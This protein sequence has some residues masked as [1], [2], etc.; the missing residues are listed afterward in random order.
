VPK[1]PAQITDYK[2]TSICPGIISLE[3]AAVLFKFMRAVIHDMRE[4]EFGRE[5]RTA[6]ETIIAQSGFDPKARGIVWNTRQKWFDEDSIPEG[7]FR[8]EDFVTP[9]ECKLNTE[10][11]F[12]E[13]GE[14]DPDQEM[15]HCLI[16]GFSLM[17]TDVNMCIV[18]CPHLM[19][20][21]IGFD[22]ADKEMVRR[23]DSELRYLESVCS[24]NAHKIDI[25][26][27]T[28]LAAFGVIPFRAHPQGT[29]PR[30]YDTRRRIIGDLGGNR[31]V[32]FDSSG[33][34]VGILNDLIRTAGFPREGKVALY[35]AMHANSILQHAARIWGE[36][37]LCFTDDFKDF[38]NQLMWARSEVWLMTVLWLMTEAH[39]AGDLKEHQADFVHILELCMC[40]GVACTSNW[41]QRFADGLLRI[42]RRH[43]LR[44]ER[45]LLQLE[46]KPER[47][48]YIAKRAVLSA[49]T[50]IEQMMLWWVG[51]YTDDTFGQVVGHARYL[52]ILK[53]W[54]WL[55]TTSNLAM[56]D[57]IKRQAGTAALW[58]GLHFNAGIGN[59]DIP[60]DK[61]MRATMALRAIADGKRVAASEPP[62]IAGL[63]GHLGPFTSTRKFRDLMQ[64]FYAWMARTK[65][66]GP[67]VLVTANDATRA[68][69]REW[70]NVLHTRRGVSC[71]AAVDDEPHAPVAGA[72]GVVCVITGDAA[73]DGAPRPGLAG[74][75]HGLFWV[76]R[77]FEEDYTGPTQIPITALELVTVIISI[78]IFGPL[79]PQ[80]ASV[81]PVFL[82]D[83]NTSVG[84]LSMDSAKAALQRML[85]AWLCGRPEYDAIKLR[86]LIGQCFG[87]ANIMSDGLS[88]GHDTLVSDLAKQMG[89]RLARLDLPPAAYEVLNVLRF[90]NLERVYNRT[91]TEEERRHGRRYS[92]DE[93]GN[94]VAAAF[95]NR[96]WSAAER[97]HGRPF[98]SNEEGDAVPPDNALPVFWP[99]LQP[100]VRT[101]TPHGVPLVP[102]PTPPS[103]TAQV[104][105]QHFS[106]LP[107]P[108]LALQRQPGGGWAPQAGSATALFSTVAPIA[109]VPV[110]D[111]CKPRALTSSAL[112]RQRSPSSFTTGNGSFGARREFGTHQASSASAD[113]IL[114]FK[115]TLARDSGRLAL[116]PQDSDYFNGLLT[117]T[118]GVIEAG[119]PSATIGKETAHMLV[120]SR[121]CDRLGTASLRDDHKANSGE[122]A[123]GHAREVLL[124][125][126]FLVMAHYTMT[127]RSKS[128]P[129]AKPASAL[130]MVA[131]VRRHHARLGITLAATP[132]LAHVLKGLLRLYVLAHGPESLQPRRKE[133]LTNEHTLAI[134]SVATGTVISGVTVDWTSPVF[135]T[136]AALLTTLR[137]AGAR[138]ADLIPPRPDTFRAPLPE[139]LQ[140]VAQLPGRYV[141][142]LDPDIARIS[143]GGGFPTRDNLRWLFGNV[144]VK[145]PTARQL[146][147]IRIGDCA[148]WIPGGSKSD[149]AA[150]EFGTK[151]VYLP[152][153]NNPVNAA[154]RLAE[155]ELA[156]PVLD[157]AKEPMFP[158]NGSG[159]S[160]CHQLA[161]RLFASLA[162]HAL[163][164]VKA[165]T[166]S[167]H[168]GRIWLASALLS[169]QIDDATI[170]SFCRWKCAASVKIYARMNARDYAKTLASVFDAD[171]SALTPQNMRDLPQI[172]N[173]DAFAELGRD[174]GIE[175]VRAVARASSPTAD[176]AAAADFESAP[177]PAAKSKKRLREARSGPAAVTSPAS[178]TPAELSAAAPKECFR[179]PFGT[180]RMHPC[181]LHELSSAPIEESVK[182]PGLLVATELFT[183]ASEDVCWFRAVLTKANKLWPTIRFESGK[184]TSVRW[185]RLRLLRL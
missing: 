46:T 121:H 102:L 24:N 111:D 59:V 112:A 107:T 126:T 157:R 81:T 63:L 86:A 165:K 142:Q 152:Y 124:I 137:H 20:L 16:D 1:S 50:G 182:R 183:N 42:L 5:S 67:G 85:V 44:E 39:R 105:S 181:A 173:D 115:Q 66:Q 125:T 177:E 72:D 101:A 136:F 77:L 143:A 43:I 170:Q 65:S 149:Q 133:P 9:P 144:I 160:L 52:R 97:Q 60:S 108:P 156:M 82:S 70:I 90:A 169:R 93:D 40:F 17:L 37:V 10:F 154:K 132:S 98:S 122:D 135:I 134:L 145:V 19:S 68:A 22:K 83:S 114:R 171:T 56:A 55:T 155:L 113:Q 64:P 34:L 159:D 49:S 51:C 73:K 45:V 166:L 129:A 118:A 11:I 23:T 140:L 26:G 180:A 164:R 15:R 3:S 131:S 88:R 6:R 32:E 185:T 174:V 96:P 31:K 61:L 30:K 150:L 87:N 36:Q 158:I 172:D 146:Q 80:L 8:P 76:L 162:V 62:K 75:M 4:N 151:P 184:T 100:R 28:M 167:L 25:D 21:S 2:P 109:V 29:V 130:A 13:L 92:S 120:W 69:A 175:P 41:A 79:L 138:K 179:D 47:L 53:R 178:D 48:A 35:E 106:C 148:I 161:D 163:G 153:Q 95:E 57:A 141:Q 18:L 104:L 58:L 99:A 127:P 74:F 110:S 117:L 14:D 7:Y 119:T 84:N 116:R 78:L 89:L 128:D 123:D 38:F 71:M 168:A 33:R 54:R 139:A 27:E 147:Q 103:F 94:A 176:N 91:L 12:N